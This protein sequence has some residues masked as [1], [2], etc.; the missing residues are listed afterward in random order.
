LREVVKDFRS[1]GKRI[2][3]LLDNSLAGE[4]DHDTAVKGSREVNDQL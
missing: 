3:M 1:K 4:N 2:A